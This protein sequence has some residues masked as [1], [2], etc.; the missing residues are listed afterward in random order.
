MR[1]I[2]KA[3]MLS[4]NKL[5]V[6]VQTKL[7]WCFE[8]LSKVSKVTQISTLRYTNCAKQTNKTSF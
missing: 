4:Y 3:S 5:E 7:R 8:T 6:D 2:T 1:D